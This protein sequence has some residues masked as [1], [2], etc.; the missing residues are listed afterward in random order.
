MGQ[1]Q[2]TGDEALPSAFEDIL[3]RLNVV[4]ERLESNDL[5]LEASLALFEEGVRLSRAG[6]ARLDE[7]E[8]RVERLLSDDG[9][10]VA[11]TE[12]REKE[13]EAP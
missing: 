1:S 11:M 3:A 4:V 5:P 7:A 10:T 2:P 6:A 13:T 9:T 12:T 8:R